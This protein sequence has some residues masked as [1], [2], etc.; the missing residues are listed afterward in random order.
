MK[1]IFVTGASGYIGSNLIKTLKNNFKVRCLIRKTA[2]LNNLKDYEIIYGDL[3][4]KASLENALKNVNIVVHLAASTNVLDQNLKEINVTGTKNLIAACKKNKIEKIVFISSTAAA[5][6]NDLYGKS[7]QEAENLIKT[8]DLDYV[9]LRLGFV[10]SKDSPNFLKIIKT[11][12][13]IQ[14]ILPVIGN[15]KYKIN[16]VNIDDVINAIIA[17]IENKKAINKTYYILGAKEL[18]FNEFLDIVIKTLGLKRIKIHIPIVFS[19]FIAKILERLINNPPITIS[20]IKAVQ[21]PTNYDIKQAKK[22][23]NYNPIDFH[24]G[25]LKL[26]DGI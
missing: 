8:S 21:T 1:T 24:S 15:G 5:K 19:L 3:R 6:A 23:L 18:E 7:K 17:S 10:Y 25:M 14:I 11:I 9:I 4:D 2:R 20:T 26:K 22:D 16:P 12:K 13:K